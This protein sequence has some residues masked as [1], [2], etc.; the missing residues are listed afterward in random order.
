MEQGK[1]QSV[2][3]LRQ[4]PTGLSQ[5]E[6]GEV[7]ALRASIPSADDRSA[8]ED[9]VGALQ[10]ILA[11]YEPGQ[12]ALDTEAWKVACA[13]GVAAYLTGATQIGGTIRPMR[14]VGGEVRYER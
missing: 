6:P 9:C 1:S 10:F 14:A 7:S 3:A 8:L 2:G 12:R 11:F 13:A 5:A 4:E